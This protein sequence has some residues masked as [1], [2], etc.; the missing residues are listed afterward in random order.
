MA[1][2]HANYRFIAFDMITGQSMRH[3]ATAAKALALGFYR[4]TD[5]TEILDCGESGWNV[6]TGGVQPT[7]PLPLFKARELYPTVFRGGDFSE[8]LPAVWLQSSACRE[9]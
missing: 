5:Y 6:W 7:N 3:A 1:I 2:R 8:A 4:S 9:G